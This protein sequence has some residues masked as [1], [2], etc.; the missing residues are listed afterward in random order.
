MFFEGTLQAVING[1]P[2][3]LMNLVLINGLNCVRWVMDV[4]TG[5]AR[6][7]VDK[8]ELFQNINGRTSPVS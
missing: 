7:P 4:T 1:S 3:N 5:S 2:R 6:L 8:F